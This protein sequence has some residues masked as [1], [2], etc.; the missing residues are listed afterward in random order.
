MTVVQQNDAAGGAGSLVQGLLGIAV[1]G[2]SR[3]VDSSLS[4]KYPLTSFNETLT[5][6][7]DGS[8]KP[9][10]APQKG[11]AATTV[12]AGALQNPIVIGVGISVVVT[13]LIIVAVRAG[14]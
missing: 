3:V 6:N 10:S 9:S 2:L 4:K 13:L 8:L 11:V 1:N 14:R 7:A 12:A 5:Y